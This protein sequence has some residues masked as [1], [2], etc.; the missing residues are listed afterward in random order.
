MSVVNERVLS[1]TYAFAG[2]LT[3]AVALILLS[4]GVESLLGQT[5][6][7]LGSAICGVLSIYYLASDDQ[8]LYG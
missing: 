2:F 6:V 4:T 8:R 1:I 3:L 5:L 7:I